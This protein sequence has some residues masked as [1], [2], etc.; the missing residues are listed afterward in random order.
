MGLISMG[1]K[2]VELTSLN[3]DQV[4]PN[5]ERTFPHPM[6]EKLGYIREAVCETLGVLIQA[7]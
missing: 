1:L 4:Y 6:A 7:P 3:I 5:S 2:I